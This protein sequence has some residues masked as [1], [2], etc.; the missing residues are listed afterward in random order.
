MKRTIKGRLAVYAVVLIGVLVW[1]QW[2]TREPAPID[3]VVIREGTVNVDGQVLEL[4]ALGPHVARQL[5]RDPRR[6]V[7]VS[8]DARA[9]STVL[10]PVLDALDRSGV[11]NV[12]VVASP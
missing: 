12:Q 6:R 10:I 5:D 7:L 1:M 3:V 9:P 2:R 8:V 4:A 11:E